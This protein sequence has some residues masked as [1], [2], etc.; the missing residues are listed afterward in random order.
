M[1]SMKCVLRSF[2][3]LQ[4][5]VR[6]LLAVEVFLCRHTYNVRMCGVTLSS[7]LLIIPPPINLPP[8]GRTH[9]HPTK[10][11]TSLCLPS[12]QCR[13]LQLW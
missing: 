1:A 11:A 12:S 7:C 6:A 10:H 3:P 5:S 8:P 13:G 2:M 4:Q 9:H